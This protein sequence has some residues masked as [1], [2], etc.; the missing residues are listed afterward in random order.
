[1][2]MLTALLAGCSHNHEPSTISLART[3]TVSAADSIFTVNTGKYTYL[4][5]SLSIGADAKEIYL[6]FANPSGSDM[7]EAATLAA[8]V[9]SQA[10]SSA[11]VKQAVREKTVILKDKPSV[12]DFEKNMPPLETGR[13]AVSPLKS[14]ADTVNDHTAFFDEDAQSVAATCRY[15][16]PVITT[17]NGARSLSV[18]VADDCWHETG[19]K[20]YTITQEMVDALAQ[21]FLNADAWNGGAAKTTTLPTGTSSYDI[22]G[23]VTS[24]FGTEWGAHSYTNLIGADGQITILLNDID[25]DNS[26][27]GGVIGLFYARDCYL[28]SNYS[29]TQY[30]NERTM[31]YIDAV[32]F[33]RPD[34]GTWSI[35]DYWPS[36]LTSTLAHEFQHMIHFYQKRALRRSGSSATWL[37]E[38]CSMAAEDLASSY[39]GINGPRAVDYSD[40]T[41]GSAGISTGRIS[42]YVGTSDRSLF[43]WPG[44]STNDVLH[45]Y[46]ESYAFGAFLA[47]SFGGSPLFG[48]IVNNSCTGTDA[49]S[50]AL[51]VMGYSE[52]F[53]T[54][55]A[56]WGAAMLLSDSTSAPEGYR[57]NCGD[58]FTSSSGN[59]P[60]TLGSI[61]VFNYVD[62][63][64]STLNIYSEYP[65][66]PL[67][68]G[69]QIL[70]DAGSMT[71]SQH[72][73]ITLPAGTILTVVAK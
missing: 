10:S 25:R 55:F 41:A 70:Y 5:Y 44:S 57:Y 2:V 50:Y 21:T 36:E 14:A 27:T 22:Y 26:T 46:G 39:L 71:G 1:M 66:T 11:A 18:W 12:I 73:T 3:D 49:V 64:G 63:S 7:S 20:A 42:D 6:L 15:T 9:Q 53:S 17:S 51:S 24:V 40:G 4:D 72:W 35:T 61:N 56:K 65:Q 8:D 31:F 47:R 34:A 29:Q 54:V 48:S 32:M 68:A 60:Y 43:Y 38:M 16:T 62:G 30:S 69:S 52:T 59:I 58:W 28:S 19:T 23:L 45:S 67:S 13:S 37:N 33:A